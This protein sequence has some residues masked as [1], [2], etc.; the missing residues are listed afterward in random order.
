MSELGSRVQVAHVKAERNVLAEV[1]NQFIVKLYYSFQVCAALLIS[2]AALRSR[3]LKAALCVQDEVYLYL[4]MEYLPGGD[5]M[6][7]H[8]LNFMFHALTCHCCTRAPSF[9]AAL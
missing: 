6:V 4:V 5:I 9:L 2:P 1:Q 8:L 7:S 3:V